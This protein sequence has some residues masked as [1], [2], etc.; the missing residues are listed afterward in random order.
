MQGHLQMQGHLEMQGHPEMQGD[1]EK[2]GHLE[3]DARRRAQHVSSLGQVLDSAA[4]T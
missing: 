3:L 2:Q 4:K 1:L